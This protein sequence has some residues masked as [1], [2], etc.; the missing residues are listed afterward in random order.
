MSPASQKLSKIVASYTEFQVAGKKVA[1]PYALAASYDDNPYDTGRPTRHANFSGKGRPEQIKQALQKATTTKYF[2][3][4]KASANEI[5]Q[6]MTQEGIGMDC[7]GFVYNVLDAY[8]RSSGQPSLNHLVLRSNNLVGKL[9]RL[10]LRKFWVRRCSADTLTNNFNTTEIS[11]A[12]DVMPGDMIRLTPAGWHGKHIAIVV[13]ATPTQITY[14]HSSEYTK[15]QGPHTATIK[16][17]DS[18]AG[19]EA[20]DWQETTLDGQNYGTFAYVPASGDSVRRLRGL[21]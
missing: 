9:E 18:Q 20:Q 10:I 5:A 14:A 19:L 3:L 16:I 11:K 13:A 15:T 1:I 4:A 7:S 2:D 12:G 21:V 17:R 8:L 6:F